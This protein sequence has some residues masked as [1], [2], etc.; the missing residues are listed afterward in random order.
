MASGLLSISRIF[1]RYKTAAAVL[2]LGKIRDIDSKPDAMKAL[3]T[4]QLQQG[5]LDEAEA[6]AKKLLTTHNDVGGLG[7]YA[8]AL[9]K[10]GRVEEAIRIYDEHYDKLVA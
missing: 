8:D 6:L 10:E 7:G 1:P 5:K 3:M 2:Y 9:V 4:A